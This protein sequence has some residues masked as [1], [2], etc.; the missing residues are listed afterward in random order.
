MVPNTLVHI[1]VQG[2]GNR[3][4]STRID[5]KW[6]FLACIIPDLPWI[7]RRTIISLA[8][9]VNIYDL[10]LYTLVQAS[11]LF[12][13]LL[14]LA[15]A[16]MSEKPR[17]VF[18]IL[19]VNSLVHL[20]LDAAEI[21]WGNGVHMF[22][23]LDWQLLSFG[24]VWPDSLLVALLSLLGLLLGIWVLAHPVSTPVRV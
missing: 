4:I 18:G 17:L 21:K 12:C 3:L 22:A 15:F 1:G 13:V 6:V 20:L 16:L 8:P 5:L 10:R 19:A 23:P 14:S 11:L 24:L 2:L 7:F 9:S